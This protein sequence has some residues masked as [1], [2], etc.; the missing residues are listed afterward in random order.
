[1]AYAEGTPLTELFGDSARVRIVAALLGERDSD[2]NVADIA[3]HA[4]VARS[5]VYDHLDQLLALGLVERTRPV[6]SSPMYSFDEESPIGER[7]SKLADVT[8]ARLLELDGE[9][10]ED[11]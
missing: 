1:E 9:R 5:T 11:D 7:V 6:G 10:L 2:L 4:G 8:L 3:R